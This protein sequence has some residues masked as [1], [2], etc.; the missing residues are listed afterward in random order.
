MIEGGDVIRHL[1]YVVQWNSRG[2]GVFVKE[3]V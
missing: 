1:L 3:K 2:F